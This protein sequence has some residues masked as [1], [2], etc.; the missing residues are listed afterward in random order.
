MSS[1][2]TYKSH[3]GSFH[4]LDSE[5]SIEYAQTQSPISPKIPLTTPI[6]SS[7]NVSGINIEV[8][9]ATAQDSTTLTIPN[10]SITPI[11]PNPTNT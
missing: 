1:S 4:D 10:I 7:I 9:N 8:G 3:S 6:A 11:P 5:S 2:N